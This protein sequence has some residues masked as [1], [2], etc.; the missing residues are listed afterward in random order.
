M[1]TIESMVL[2]GMSVADVGTDHGF[3]PADLLLKG[4]CPF[5]VLTDI[6][7]G[8]L[9]KCRQNLI[10][11]GVDPSKY[12]IRQGDGFAPLNSGEVASI[13]LAGMGGELMRSIF[14]RA[15]FGLM[16]NDKIILAQ[17]Y[18]LQPRTHEE[19]IRSFLTSSCFRI[20]DYRLARERG[21]ICEV[22][23]V[24]QCQAGQFRTDNGIV[25]DFLLENGDPLLKEYLDLKMTHLS[26]ILNSLEGSKTADAERQKSIFSA[27]LKVLSEISNNI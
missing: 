10:S 24:E 20:T 18:I 7:S 12:S 23:A 16:S 17:R 15:E 26:S 14:E 22:F 13:I 19:D 4:I 6:N 21:R 3:I 8:P 5:A 11:L 25:S 1:R 9:E 27:Q 2:S